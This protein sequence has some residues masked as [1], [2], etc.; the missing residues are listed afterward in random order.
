MKAA[1]G[2]GGLRKQIKVKKIKKFGEK[3]HNQPKDNDLC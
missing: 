2:Y 1:E 3:T